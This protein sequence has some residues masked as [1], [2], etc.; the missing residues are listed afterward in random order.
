MIISG[1]LLLVEG[2]DEDYVFQ[3]YLSHLNLGDIQIEMVGGKNNFAAKFPALVKSTGFNKVKTI[4]FIRDADDSPTGAFQSISDLLTREGYNPPSH[5]GSVSTSGEVNIGVYILP[6]N[7]DQGCLEDLLLE[8]I[9]N[10]S[11][12]ECIEQWHNCI[13]DKENKPNQNQVSKA[14]TQVFLASQKKIAPSIGIGAKKGY[15]D[16]SSSQFDSLEHFL[17]EL[18]EN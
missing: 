18:F 7:L 12:Y 1:N 6:N 10:K 5:K 3:E 13:K 2:K 8:T 9:K 4:G 16:F 11:E 14:K 17:L 15:W